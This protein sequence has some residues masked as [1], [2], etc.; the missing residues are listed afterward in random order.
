MEVLRA[1][2]IDVQVLA[3]SDS[4][5]DAPEGYEKPRY[6]TFFETFP[7]K[8]KTL[9]NRLK[10]NFGG[11]RASVKAAE[12]MGDFDVVLCT[13]P[14][15]LLT[16]AAMTIA[17]KK[18]AKLVLDVRD[19]WP[20]VAYE[21]GCFTPGSLYGRF[22]SLIAKRG[23]RAADLVTTVSAGKVRS[24]GGVYQPRKP[25]LCLCPMA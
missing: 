9:I 16:S 6:V 14:P 3:S 19:I 2:G 17:R 12:A 4:L 22:F 8:E 21:M 23:F 7:L 13:T 5:L 11:L 15:L 24:F 25:A 18:H 1:E 10:N 20:D